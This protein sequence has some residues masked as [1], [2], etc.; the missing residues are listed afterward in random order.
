M[1][2]SF[3]GRVQESV[4]CRRIVRAKASDVKQEGTCLAIQA[5]EREGECVCL[6]RIFLSW[7]KFTIMLVWSQKEFSLNSSSYYMIHLLTCSMGTCSQHTRELDPQDW[8]Q[9]VE[10][11]EDVVGAVK[12][13]RTHSWALL[14]GPP[15]SCFPWAFCFTSPHKDVFSLQLNTEPCAQVVR[16]SGPTPSL[17]FWKVSP[18][19][20]I[21]HTPTD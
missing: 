21:H 6:S 4:E 13:G 3:L 19:Q 11:V 15:L 20:T 1:S 2:R 18:W 9:E 10:K 16:A 5:K 12:G 14:R 7:K 17:S 8:P